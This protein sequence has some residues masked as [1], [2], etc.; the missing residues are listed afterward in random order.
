MIVEPMELNLF[1]K[2]YTYA[3]QV[4]CYPVRN[5]SPLFNPDNSL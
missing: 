5:K 3:L 1:E 4:S 2:E